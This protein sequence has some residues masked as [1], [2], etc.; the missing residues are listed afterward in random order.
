MQF[1][2]LKSLKPL[3]LTNQRLYQLASCNEVWIIHLTR[4]KLIPLLGR[5]WDIYPSHI[6]SYTKPLSI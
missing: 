5:A 3:S 4:N 2:D 6:L 1:L